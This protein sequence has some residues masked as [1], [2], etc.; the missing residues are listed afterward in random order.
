MSAIGWVKV[1]QALTIA[2]AFFLAVHKDM[3]MVAFAPAGWDDSLEI[4]RIELFC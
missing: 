4:T 2:G 1:R 3:G